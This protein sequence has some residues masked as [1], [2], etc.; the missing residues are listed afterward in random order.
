MLE[1]EQQL[2]PAE[3]DLARTQR[4]QLGAV[5]TLYRALGGGWDVPVPAWSEPLV[6]SDAGERP[7]SP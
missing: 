7:A 1:A 5:V 6:A 4:D 2:F 3:L